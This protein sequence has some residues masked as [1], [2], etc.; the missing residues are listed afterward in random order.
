MFI[1]C[2]PHFLCVFV[3]FKDRGK[4]GAKTLEILLAA[5]EKA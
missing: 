1:E 2:F 5:R 4:V 3:I